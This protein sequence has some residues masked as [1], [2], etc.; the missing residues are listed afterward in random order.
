MISPRTE[1]HVKRAEKRLG[2]VVDAVL[3]RGYD[4]VSD[5]LDDYSVLLT[6]F[7]FRKLVTF[8]L[9]E[10]YCSPRRHEFELQLLTYVVEAVAQSKSA[11]FLGKAALSGIVGNTFYEVSK[12]L[13]SHVSRKLKGHKKLSR[14]FR[15]IEKNLRSIRAYFDT[16]EQARI[17]E[18]SAALDLESVK[19]ET[20]LKLLGFKCRRRNKQRVWIRPSGW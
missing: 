14:P 13:F 7:E 6:Q 3:E 20:L 9:Y 17:E 8:Q 4:D 15:E 10:V 1:D 16:R 11:V 19:L 18:I 2:S 12:R 5:E